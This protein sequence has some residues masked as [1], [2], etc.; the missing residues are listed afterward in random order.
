[1]SHAYSQ[2]HDGY[3]LCGLS[4]SNVTAGVQH[5]AIATDDIIFTVD[6]LRRRGVDFLYVPDNYYDTVMERVGDINE[7]LD[8]LKRAPDTV[9]GLLANNQ[10]LVFKEATGSCGSGVSIRPVDEMTAS[11]IT[12]CMEHA[13][14]DMVETFVEQHAAL[15]SL[16]LEAMSS[17][18]SSTAEL[19]SS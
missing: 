9:E 17:F 16:S 13:G 14:F 8:D 12:E 3:T 11:E 7:S 1:M 4:Q 15:N 10:K 19:I 18:L 6:E 2:P 5:I